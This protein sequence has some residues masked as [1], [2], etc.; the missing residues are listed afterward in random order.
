MLTHT[1]AK[2]LGA[3]LFALLCFSVSSVNKIDANWHTYVECSICNHNISTH[4]LHYSY[5]ILGSFNL[6]MLLVQLW[7]KIVGLCFSLGGQKR[8]FWK[9]W[10]WHPHL[11][12]GLVSSAT[13]F[14]H[15]HNSFLISL[16]VCV[17]IIFLDAFSFCGNSFSVVY[18]H[19]HF[20]L[21]LFFE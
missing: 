14:K 20:I 3:S 9:C 5:S 7:L 10:C 8:H 11:F 2:E 13:K 19:D 15:K 12:T 4:H 1:N 17:W 6:K 21:G 18:Y 16:N